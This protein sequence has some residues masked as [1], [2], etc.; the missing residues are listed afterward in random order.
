MSFG[1]VKS[2]LAWLALLLTACQHRAEEPPLIPPTPQEMQVWADKNCASNTDTLCPYYA[3]MQYA[4]QRNFYNANRYRGREC[5]LEITYKNGRYAVQST[6]GD[7]QLCVK[8]WSVIGSAKNLPPPPA[9][10]PATLVI[11]FKPL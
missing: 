5:A 8:A 11:D 1:K 7:E 6:T 10:L 4:I 2:G 3:Q 9:S